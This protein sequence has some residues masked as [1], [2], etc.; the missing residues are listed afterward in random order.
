LR[1][2]LKHCMD[3]VYTLLR[4]SGETVEKDEIECGVLLR[5]SFF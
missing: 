2:Y 4:T 3:K 5:P 1:I